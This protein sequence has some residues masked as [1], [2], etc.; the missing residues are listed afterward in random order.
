MSSIEYPTSAA[1]LLAKKQYAPNAEIRF[2]MKLVTDL[3][4]ECTIWA[5]FFRRSLI[6]SMLYLLRSII[7]SW[8]DISLFFIFTLRPVTNW[9]P[10]SNK[11]SKSFC[12]IYPLSANSLPY[13]R[14]ANTSNTFGS[15]SLT[16]AP[17]STN[18]ISSPLSL[19]A[20]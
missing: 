4:R 13:K 11:A 14:L 20:R 5:V 6:V 1:G 12:E 8:N 9:M 7:L 16:F 18:A 3:C 15:L 10:S 19:Q 17:V 2:M